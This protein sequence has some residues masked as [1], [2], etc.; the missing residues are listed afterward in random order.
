MREYL[1][2]GSTSTRKD[3]LPQQPLVDKIICL[4]LS[5]SPCL[6]PPS[7]CAKVWDRDQVCAQRRRVLL[8]K[9]TLPMLTPNLSLA[10]IVLV[11][12]LDLS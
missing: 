2:L 6:Q 11:V 3:L 1:C 9:G 8:T 10:Q 7:T 12:V 5:V 4:T